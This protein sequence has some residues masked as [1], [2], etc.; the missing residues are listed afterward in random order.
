[1]LRHRRYAPVVEFG[2]EDFT[3]LVKHAWSIHSE[4]NRV[5]FNDVTEH[6]S[7]AKLTKKFGPN[8]DLVTM[9]IRRMISSLRAFKLQQNTFDKKSG[10]GSFPLSH[11]DGRVDTYAQVFEVLHA[12]DRGELDDQALKNVI[13][14]KLSCGAFSNAIIGRSYQCVLGTCTA[15][16]LLARAEKHV[17]R[18]HLGVEMETSLPSRR[19]YEP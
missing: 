7:F 17:L 18:H 13:K 9:S 1:M 15:T 4:R 3:E 10:C 5:S 14:L 2:S 11:N 19:T 16:D 8:S 6:R 12:H